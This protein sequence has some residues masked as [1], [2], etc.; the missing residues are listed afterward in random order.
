MVKYN[1]RF[2]FQFT[3]LAVKY[4]L[5]LKFCRNPPMHFSLIYFLELELYNKIAPLL[6]QTNFFPKMQN[7]FKK[8]KKKTNIYVTTHK[9]TL[10]TSALS[11]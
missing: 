1:S 7:I 8:K 9:K 4:Q 3:R 10:A 5:K 2:K 6:W 11:P